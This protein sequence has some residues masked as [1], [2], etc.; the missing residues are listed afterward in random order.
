MAGSDGGRVT[1]DDASIGPAGGATTSHE[2]TDRMVI[3]WD[4]YNV[5][6]DEV[7]TYIQP[8]AD[9]IA[10]NRIL[11]HSGSEIHGQINANGQVVLVNP[12]GVFF[13][14]NAQVNV[15]GLIASGMTVDVSDF[16]NGDFTFS[17][18]DG[19]EGKVI[20]QGLIN[21]ATGGSV[22]LLGKQVRNDGLISARL[23]AVNLAAG[24]E[25]VVT[26]DE[27]GLMGV[28]IS[29]EI[30]QNELGVDAAILNTGEIT[31]GGGRI[32]LSASTSRDIFS[33]AVNR[34]DLQ[35][36]T[37]AVVHEDG[38]FTL[39]GGADVVNTGTLN[40]SSADRGAG[41]IVVLGENV[42]QAGTVL[43][44]T[45]SGTS[46]TIELHAAHT[47]LLTEN[48]VTAARAEGRGR[49]GTIQVLGHH[50]GVIDQAMVDA[51]GAWGGGQ[52]Y[53]GGDYQG[54][55]PFMPN[56]WRSFV[57]DQAR[58]NANALAD[59]DGGRIIVW[60]DDIARFFGSIEGKGAGENGTGGFAEVSGKILLRF[61][62]LADMR[63]PGGVGTLLLDPQDIIITDWGDESN[64]DPD[65]SFGDGEADEEF[66]ISPTTLANNINNAN[67]Q[68]EATR[69]ITV[70]DGISTNAENSHS[71]TLWAGKSINIESGI[72]LGQGDLSL[73]AG[74]F[75]CGEVDC[76]S[77]DGARS[78]EIGG[79]LNTRGAIDIRAADNITLKDH[80]GTSDNQPASVSFRAGNNITIDNDRNVHASAAPNTTAIS[81]VAGDT[82]LASESITSAPVPGGDGNLVINGNLNSYGTADDRGGDIF[83]N[84][85]G[86]L[87]LEADVMTQG[88][89]FI[90]GINDGI[91]PTGFSMIGQTVNT[92]TASG[93]TGLDAG[94]I[95]IYTSGNADLGV[96]ST[97]LHWSTVNG[98]GG[99]NSIGTITV[100]AG[101]DITL[102]EDLD[103]NDFG[104]RTGDGA[105]EGDALGE[106]ELSFTAGRNITLNGEIYDLWGD[107]RDALNIDLKA[108]ATLTLNNNIYTSGGNFTASA[109]E[110]RFGDE[111]TISTRFANGLEGH[112]TAEHER[113]GRADWSTGGNVTLSARTQ[114]MLGKVVTH[115]CIDIASCTGNLTLSGL[116][117]GEDVIN[118]SITQIDNSYLESPYSDKPHPA[119]SHLDIAG[120]TAI[121]IGTGTATLDSE[122]NKFHGAVSGRAGS[123]EIVNNEA[124]LTFGALTLTGDLTAT[125][126]GSI[127]DL[128]S[129][130]IANI[131][132]VDG[133]ATF[134]TNENRLLLDNHAHQLSTVKI[135]GSV[136]EVALDNGRSLEV[137]GVE[138]IDEDGT[139]DVKAITTTGEAG[140]VDINVA[141]DLTILGAVS[142]RGVDV[143]VGEGTRERDRGEITLVAQGKLTVGELNASG[144][145]GNRG[146]DGGSITLNAPDVELQ[147]DIIS[148]GSSGNDNSSPGAS[149]NITI[150]GNVVIAPA[151]SWQIVVD[152][153]GRGDPAGHSGN[154]VLN[155]TLNGGDTFSRISINSGNIT[156][157]GD[158]GNSTELDDLIINTYGDVA[159]N[160]ENFP[161]ADRI[162]VRGQASDHRLTAP[163]VAG[164]WRILW[165]DV[166]RLEARDGPLRWIQ[167]TNM[168]TLVG[169]NFDDRFVIETIGDLELSII[170]NRNGGASNGTNVNTL[171]ASNQNNTWEIYEGDE[172]TLNGSLR[173]TGFN[174]LQG[175][176]GTDHFLLSGPDLFT[177]T[178]NGGDGAGNSV[179]SEFEN[180][181]WTLTEGYDGNLVVDG[182]ELQFKNIQTLAGS[183]SDSLTG[184]DQENV[185]SWTPD[186]G[187]SVAWN[188]PD[189]ADSFEIDFSGMNHLIGGGAADRIQSSTA[190]GT[191]VMTNPH[192][193]T[194]TVSG[195][196]L[197]FNNMQTLAGSG[198]DSLTRHDQNNHWLIT[199]SN[200]GQ[201]LESDGD[202]NGGIENGNTTNFS[203]MNH[204]VGGSNSDHFVFGAEGAVTGGI[205]G[206][207]E[208]EGVN[209][210]IVGRN[211]SNRWE[212]GVSDGA[213][214]GWITDVTLEE[215]GDPSARY[216]NE[217]T[218]IHSLQGGE[219]TD[220]F[221]YQTGARNIALDGGGGT[222]NSVDFSRLGAMDVLLDEGPMTNVVNIQTLIGGGDGFSLGVVNG[223]NRWE[224]DDEY[225]GVLRHDRNDDGDFAEEY[226]FINFAELVGGTGIDTLVARDVGNLWRL[227]S[228]N[229]GTLDRLNPE[230]T[231]GSNAPLTFS[232]MDHLI[233]GTDEDHFVLSGAD[234]FTGTLNGG[235]GAG[236]SV[237]SEF[238]N[239]RWT[240][241]E[242]YDGN[243]VVGGHELQFKNIQTLAGSGSDSLTGLDQENVWSW[244]PDNG[245]SVAWND[246]DA[247]D[248]FEI[249]F[250]GMNHL[251]G[252]GDSDRLNSSTDNGAWVMTEPHKGALTVS[253]ADQEF[254]LSF[255]NMQTLEGSGTDTLT[256]HDQNNHWQITGTNSGKLLID[257]G[258]ENDRTT[259]FSGM[260]QLIGG[261]NSDHLRFGE[262]GAVTGWIDGGA[263]GEG[264]INTIVG[265]DTDNRWQIG[266]E[267]GDQWGSI[268]EVTSTDNGPEYF[269]YLTKFTGI[270]RLQGGAGSDD[271]IYQN[272]AQHIALDG[273]EGGA[274]RVDFSRLDSLAVR[275]N[276][277]PMTDITNVQ[278]LI[279][280]GDEFSIGV[281]NG[282][283][284][285]ELESDRSGVLHHD[286]QE[287]ERFQ[288]E[289]SFINF[290]ELV[291]G[292]GTDT[293]L[294][295]D[296]DNYIGNH[297]A[298]NSSDGG[299]LTRLEP[300][301]SIGQFAPLTFA[302][303]NHLI[304][305]TEEDHFVLSGDDLFA[306][307]LDGGEGLGNRV[308]STFGDGSWTLTDHYNGTLTA[309]GRELHFENI[310]TLQGSGT[311]SLQGLSQD[312]VWIWTPDNG[313]SVALDNPDAPDS[314]TI[315][316]SGMN[317]LIGGGDSDRLSSSTDNGAW[318]MTAPHEGS[319]TVSLADQEFVLS[320]ENMQTLE[321]SGSDALT[322]HDQNNHW[323]ITSTNGGMLL[324][325]DENGDRK[326]VV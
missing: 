141:G 24:K 225:S 186:N 239:G 109:D 15:G 5:A 204:L 156:F 95:A 42:S 278:T 285:W 11:S 55:N 121:N 99:G 159:F 54:D 237:E 175:G 325:S 187:G 82:T 185:W 205:D 260:H 168:S 261:N 63:G 31:A 213:Q 291:G 190:N 209:N 4:S 251:I 203:G 297:W 142:T 310:Q 132:Q 39:G 195:H 226:T 263:T 108:G 14:K 324:E 103:C 160:T 23:G 88:G 259:Y 138:T 298:L 122:N 230:E 38:S 94:N 91:R 179:E 222:D 311:D 206:G 253:L 245:G 25:A 287:D 110:I 166:G 136:T 232:G 149:G 135:L 36:A 150:D 201:L 321:G 117:V 157:N 301:E 248:S 172:S 111:G 44:S 153:T 254:V 86:Q 271:F 107:S 56:A 264:I 183:G 223:N 72:N 312:N 255:E 50:V 128:A 87:T 219:G 73:T 189:A 143:D 176:G 151:D 62:G 71:L 27:A 154:F 79:I 256:R 182:H 224:L 92:G 130:E 306:G 46:G 84:A 116:E 75:S 100:D 66:R 290:A 282:E 314:F 243:L 65:V 29:K 315:D 161:Q 9:A 233:G 304:G 93:G 238:A 26:F 57:G 60:A 81:L 181:R 191:W 323:L 48:S 70:E 300:E 216:L 21:A 78:V 51:S 242:G 280:G 17:A 98:A 302:G 83:L 217:F 145:S 289:Y 158:I 326:S 292:S 295:K 90:V 170:A 267:D 309:D 147:G 49:G 250:S 299:I 231:A 47:V 10:L 174:V 58:I 240:L 234:L 210:T 308:E 277:G 64:V 262:E 229:G 8:G 305:G 19:A 69:N 133:L 202:G 101:G 52:V 178:L 265:R 2:H 165:P 288:A 119:N 257:G 316:F 85:A 241:T 68:L 207:G 268:A 33:N 131:I 129:D 313:G 124:G 120:T 283:N 235:D 43:A 140:K 96:M 171:V 28:R 208:G 249:D 6:A 77:G 199:S 197:R 102:H 274:N 215:D 59:G 318:V 155:G 188:D 126:A 244:T 3:D 13:G 220:Q 286:Q 40:V 41:D 214:R 32:L 118:P 89:H 177:G 74:V 76:Y 104:P 152:N 34:G 192:Q 16:M 322:R 303:M 67:V 200:G 193:G 317:E 127:T 35:Q 112:T 221:V 246:P 252:G 320:F 212:I 148:Q 228:S 115:N 196:E 12:H 114:M 106:S 269:I 53:I 276:E 198:S 162:N 279:G 137:R 45:Q 139:V 1:D 180:G 294:A 30:L 173:F 134:D 236:N 194:L 113:H 284:L 22:T 146:R 167:F 275:L 227:N 169:S 97:A 164:E 7:V 307:V 80:I 319:L 272:G 184:L 123:L 125:A 273:G 247:A 293:L 218:G 296:V 163:D 144:G 105:R 37:S 281:A 211:T 61:D 18:V 266:V 20:N 258:V 270:D